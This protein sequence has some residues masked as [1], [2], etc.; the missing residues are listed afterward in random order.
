MQSKSLVLACV[1]NAMLW[2]VVFREEDHM[3]ELHHMKQEPQSRSQRQPPGRTR[4]REPKDALQEKK[5]FCG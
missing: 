2:C 3:C 5:E 1:E 4:E